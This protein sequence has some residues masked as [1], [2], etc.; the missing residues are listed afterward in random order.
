M[1]QDS[2]DTITTLLSTFEKLGKNRFKEQ[3]EV[4]ELLYR[5]TAFESEAAIHH[6]TALAALQEFDDE[7]KLEFPKIADHLLKGSYDYQLEMD[8][9]RMQPKYRPAKKRLVELARIVPEQAKLSL[10]EI[11][12]EYEE[13]MSGIK[14]KV[15]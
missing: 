14:V 9:D 12:R 1:L 13:M 3:I 2:V 10:M 5:R 4:L 11:S 15:S 7:I 8:F 6:K